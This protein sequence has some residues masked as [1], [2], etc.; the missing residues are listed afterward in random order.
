MHDADAVVARLNA[1]E[2]N[3]CAFS[4][5][6]HASL[7][8]SWSVLACQLI[9]SPAKAKADLGWEPQTSFEDLI[10]LMTRAD[11]GLLKP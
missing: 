3:G 4:N 11:L 1:T 7:S 10:R 8:A 2:W 9:G 6:S 5:S